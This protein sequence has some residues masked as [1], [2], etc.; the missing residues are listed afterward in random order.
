MDFIMLG[1]SLRTPLFLSKGE[2][3]KVRLTKKA[4]F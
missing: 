4:S 2:E 1:A 3:L